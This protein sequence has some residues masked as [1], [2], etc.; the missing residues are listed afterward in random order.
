M[1]ASE[2]KIKSH[3]KYSRFDDTGVLEVSPSGL[4]YKSMDST[5][6]MSKK[7]IKNISKVAES[8]SPAAQMILAV[9]GLILILAIYSQKLDT[10]IIL[11]LVGITIVGG[12]LWTVVFPKL[13]KWTLIEYLDGS[14]KAKKAYFN[15]VGI[16]YSPFGDLAYDLYF[17]KKSKELYNVI[18][19]TLG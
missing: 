12:A 14:G 6:S 2:K 11:L 10:N 19:F 17:S 3:L 8:S 9:V 4:K 15:A 5:M 1:Y 13:S 16:P 7:Q 18:S